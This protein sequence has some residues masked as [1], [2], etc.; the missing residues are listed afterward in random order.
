VA[1]GMAAALQGSCFAFPTR[2][3]PKLQND[4]DPDIR[5]TEDEAS[6]FGNKSQ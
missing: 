2:A 5:L 3:L 4:P 1:A 6:W